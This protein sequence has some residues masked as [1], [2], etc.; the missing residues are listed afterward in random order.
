MGIVPDE[1]ML[2]RFQKILDKSMDL[3][4]SS[5]LKSTRFINSNEITI[6][7]IKAVCEFTQFWLAEIDVF[8]DRPRLQEWLKDCRE[9]LNPHFDQV[10]SVVYKIRDK[11]VFKSK[12]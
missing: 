9:S 8:K 1:K 10:H 4:E 12:L 2:K 7:D 5:F 3:L 6:A 11:G